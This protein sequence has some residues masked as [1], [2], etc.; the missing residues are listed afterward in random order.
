MI[1]ALA[2]ALVTLSP[3]ETDKPAAAYELVNAFPAQ[4]KFDKPLLLEHHPSDPDVYYVVEQDGMIYRVPRDG[5]RGERS[6]FLDWTD[7]AHTAN[8]EEGLLGLAFGPSHAETGDVYIYYSQLV[9]VKRRQ[10]V[11]SRLETTREDAPRAHEDSEFVVMT[12]PQPYG[13]HNGG[14]IVFGPDKML[15]VVLGDGGAANDPRDNGQNLQTL[16]GSVLRIDVRHSNADEPYRIPEDNPF[17]GRQDARGEIWAYGLRNLWRISFDRD[18]GDLWGADVGQNRWEEVDRIVKG[19]NYGWNLM[20][21]THE[22]TPLE[23]DAELPDDLIAPVAEYA[24]EVGL[25]VTGGYVYRGTSMPELVGRYVYGDFVT[26]RVW[27]VREGEDGA[28]AD[29]MELCKAPATIAAF[30][31]EPDGELL[32][33]SFDGKIYRLTRKGA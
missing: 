28:E 13:N 14:T 2:V 27:A 5:S 33:L 7:R 32:L 8:W 20:E 11:I 3:Q 15:Y 23:V 1:S 18:T 17:V 12:V 22:F 19:G 26:G 29:V 4:E 25:S 31:Q 10:S 24:H 21:G 6:V 16:L 9:G 30:G